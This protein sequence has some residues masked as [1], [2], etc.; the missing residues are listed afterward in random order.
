MLRCRKRKQ[1]GPSWQRSRAAFTAVTVVG[2]ALIFLTWSPP[3]RRG[4]RNNQPA[5]RLWDQD[6][7]WAGNPN[8]VPP[9]PLPK[10][11]A[12]S[13]RP[14]P[15]AT[16]P[17]PPAG[18]SNPRPPGNPFE[19]VGSSSGSSGTSSISSNSNASPSGSNTNPPPPRPPPTP[20]YPAAPMSS[21]SSNSSPSASYI[22]SSVATQQGS[23]NARPQT[24]Q[25]AQ[26][27][28]TEPPPPPPQT[29]QI[30]QYSQPQEQQTDPQTTQ[31]LTAELPPQ[32][33]QQVQQNQVD[34]TTK[35]TTI[36]SAM[37]LSGIPSI[38][39]PYGSMER[40]A[41]LNLLVHRIKSSITSVS[42]DKVLEVTILSIG[43]TSMLSRRLRTAN[44]F[45][46]SLGSNY[47]MQLVKYRAV[48][49]HD[50]AP[51]E[52]ELCAKN[53]QSS[54]DA[55][56]QQLSPTIPSIAPSSSNDS[57]DNEGEDWSSITNANANE[58]MHPSQSF[59]WLPSPSSNVDLQI[60]TSRPTP[61]PTLNPSSSATEFT[62]PQGMDID[63]QIFTSQPTPH[64]TANEP[65]SSTAI[66]ENKFQGDASKRYCGYDWDDIVRNC[67]TATPCPE[68]HA[69]GVCPYG[70]TCIADTPCGGDAQEEQEGGVLQEPPVVQQEQVTYDVYTILSSSTNSSPHID[71]NNNNNNSISL[72]CS[73]HSDCHNQFCSNTDGGYEG[74]CV[75][76]LFNSNIGCRA[77][78]VCVTSPTTGMPLCQGRSTVIESHDQVA[79]VTEE[80]INALQP[81][82]PPSQPQYQNPQDNSY[83]CGLT[84]ADVT[85]MCLHSK[86]CPT[87]IAALHCGPKEGCFSHPACKLQY[88]AAAATSSQS[89]SGGATMSAFSAFDTVETEMNVSSKKGEQ[90]GTSGPAEQAQEGMRF[91]TFESWNSANTSSSSC[92][93]S[94]LTVVTCGVLLMLL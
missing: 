73:S 63:S 26:A 75:A 50:C 45:D 58:P 85:D 37:E 40:M 92:K 80:E 33:T 52:E 36:T 77:T 30:Q 4:A 15:S 72:S 74:S 6:I 62:G 81:T 82:S 25:T 86:P 61:H 3:I 71:N 93:A 16:N 19:N 79:V 55:I 14:P 68:G 64:P 57:V 46:R 18:P 38:I 56:A 35:T 12:Y 78:E 13:Y 21:P 17:S 24:Q 67:L 76:C 29:Q 22:I 47:G 70:M 32:Q 1:P 51:Q 48:L 54:A 88:D 34:T 43:Q 42:Q 8:I 83:F 53:A 27:V 59:V 7:F 49:E 39:P 90:G 23:S 41:L 60:V 44:S 87:G 20:A 89:S 5:R 10:P 2:T 66:T 84:Y 65:S 11:P 94:L 31:A 69:E 28:A 91:W 9:P